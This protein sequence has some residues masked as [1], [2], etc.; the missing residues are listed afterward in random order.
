[1]N[2]EFYEFL[3]N[4]RS[5]GFTHNTREKSQLIFYR[6]AQMSDPK[7]PFSVTANH[8]GEIKGSVLMGEIGNFAYDNNI[9][10]RNTIIGIAFA[11][12]MHAMDKHVDLETTAIIT[13]YYIARAESISTAEEFNMAIKE[14]CQVFDD[15]THIKSWEPYGHPIDACIDYIY[16]N[17]YSNFGVREV[18]QALEY[19]PSYLST[20]FK[21][22]TGQPLHCFIKEAKLQEARVL[23]LYT[24]Q[25][26]TSIASSLGFHSLSHFSKAFKAAEGISPLRFRR[27]GA[28]QKPGK[29]YGDSFLTKSEQQTP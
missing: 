7:K 23:L 29:F 19:D 10:Y 4:L 3:Y 17:L 14:M 24:S 12:N 2:K 9:N 27:Q 11:L 22:R 20:L 13:D 5:S 25:P 26:L 15:L 8:S 28:N 16:R 6:N 18:A 1:M 21:K